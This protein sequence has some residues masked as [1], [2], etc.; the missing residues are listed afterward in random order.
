[1]A[2]K[3]SLFSSHSFSSCVSE[4]YSFLAKQLALLARVMLPYFTL[5]ALV[6]T[7]YSAYTVKLNV[8]MQAEGAIELNE[9]VTAIVLWTALFVTLMVSMARFYLLFRRLAMLEI[10][11]TKEIYSTRWGHC[12]QSLVRTL[13]LT[14]KFIPYTIWGYLWFMPGLAPGEK[15]L[16]YIATLP[17]TIF[18]AASIALLII[19]IVGIILVQPLVYTLSCSLL[20]PTSVT[21]KNAP[22]DM[23]T[24]NFKPA[25]R[26]AFHHKSKIFLLNLWMFFL[27]II[28]SMLILLP[29]IVCVYAYFRSVEGVINFGDTSYIPT[30]GYA[31]MLLIG[32]L[33]TTFCLLL[34]VPMYVANIYLFGDIY[35]KKPKEQS[36]D[37]Q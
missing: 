19:A 6:C 29:G 18:I 37:K 11:S 16:N 1:M 2:D 21:D 13:Q 27:W 23:S 10:P 31:L 26:A 15:L 25:Y 9:L 20:R 30:A 24:F 4:G 14:K 35:T 8:Q 5:T 7:L 33:A 22:V 3:I 32:T 17:Q 28:S 36:N 12:K 34:Q